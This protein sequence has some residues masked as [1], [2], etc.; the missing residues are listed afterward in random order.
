M[1]LVVME[2]GRGEGEMGRGRYQDVEKLF[3][4]WKLVQPF[5]GLLVR[6]VR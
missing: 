3:A 2:S 6:R 4:G 1:G 5:W